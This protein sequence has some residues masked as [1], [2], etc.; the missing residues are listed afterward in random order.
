MHDM[1]ELQSD[2][3]DIY[4]QRT[5][6]GLIALFDKVGKTIMNN[7]TKEYEETAK[8]IDSLRNWDFAFS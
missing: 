2:L 1:M 3:V 7:N 5:L 6:P 8:M 4:V